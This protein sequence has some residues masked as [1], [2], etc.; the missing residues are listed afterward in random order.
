MIHTCQIVHILEFPLLYFGKTLPVGVYLMFIA[1]LSIGSLPSWFWNRLVK[2]VVRGLKKRIGH[3]NPKVQL[4]AL[5]VSL[6]ISL[7]ICIFTLL[8]SVLYYYS[9][10]CYLFEMQLLLL[11]KSFFMHFFFGKCIFISLI[12]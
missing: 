6:Q 8:T 1:P 12:F 5:T 3:K 10:A 7:M 11:V 9:Y 2:D 4:L